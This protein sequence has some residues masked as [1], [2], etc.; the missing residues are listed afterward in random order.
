MKTK[1]LSISGIELRA[2]IPEDIFSYQQLMTCLADYRKPRDRVSQLLESGEIVRIRKG[3]YTFTEAL[4]RTPVCRELLANLIYGPSYLTAE[5]ALSYYGLIPERVTVMTSVTT[6]RS[7]SFETPFGMFSYR[8]IISSIYSPGV[9]IEEAGKTSFLIATPEKALIDKVWLDKNFPGTTM[10]G[11]EAYLHDDLRLD[12]DRIKEFDAGR[13]RKIAAA[14]DRPKI[15]R[16][17]KYLQT[18][19]ESEH[20]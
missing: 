10:A 12:F 13:L 9:T 11:F 1:N 19:M 2:M 6:G 17:C 3:L 18:I 16:L 8:K 20:E 15:N 5:Y 4:R 14:C 7:C